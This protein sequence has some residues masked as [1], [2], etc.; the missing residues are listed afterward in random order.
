MKALPIGNSIAMRLIAPERQYGF[1]F[2]HEQKLSSS[3][4]LADRF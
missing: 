4:H 3:A 2:W 1:S